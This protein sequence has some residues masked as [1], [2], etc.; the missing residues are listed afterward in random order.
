MDGMLEDRTQTDLT[1]VLAGKASALGYDDLPAPVRA[2][3]RQCV[4]DYLGVALAGA[5][6]SARPDSARRDGGGR[7]VSAGERHWP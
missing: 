1:R 4:L 7:R 6:R 5:A 3:A 2:V